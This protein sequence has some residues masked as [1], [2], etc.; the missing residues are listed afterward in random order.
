MHFL[1]KLF[2]LYIDIKNKF[3]FKKIN[4]FLNKNT[5]KNNLRDVMREFDAE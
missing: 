5:L 3:F 4:I 1:K 2:I